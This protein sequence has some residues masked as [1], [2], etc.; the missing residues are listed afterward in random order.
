MSPRALVIGSPIAHSLSPLLHQAGYAS[1]GLTDWSY[2]RAQ[3]K[4]DE[5]ETFVAGLDDDVRGLSVTMP[6]KEAALSLASRSSTLAREVGAANTLVREADG[7]F[8]D[9]TDV[10][11]V[12]HALIAAGCERAQTAVILGSG[13]TARS[14]V[15][16][17]AQLGVKHVTFA[18]RGEVRDETVALA[19]VYNMSTDV[20]RL[21]DDALISRILTGPLTLSTLPAGALDAIADRLGA[22]AQAGTGYVFDV[23]YANWPTPLARAAQSKGLGVVSGLE[24]LI[25]QAAVQF[26]LFTGHS[27]PIADMRRAAW[28]A[29]EK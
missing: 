19:Q 13:A 20:I 1:A 5:V 23:V 7:W 25:E 3:V 8:A 12:L 24:M 26:V 14:C 11:G 22:S 17:V 21:D 4:A 28:A 29:V 27:A 6:D 18:V 16:A 10:A 2:D 15:A 9:N